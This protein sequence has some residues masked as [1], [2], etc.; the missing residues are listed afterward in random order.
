MFNLLKVGDVHNLD[1]ATMLH[2]IH[3]GNPPDNFKRLF[4]PLNQI[5]FPKPVV[6]Q[7]GVILAAS[8]QVCKKIFERTRLNILEKYSSL[9]LRALL[10]CIQTTLQL[11]SP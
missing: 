5:I 2:T 10:I 9:L 6:L 3:S 7:R 1:I 4:A 8:K 11:I